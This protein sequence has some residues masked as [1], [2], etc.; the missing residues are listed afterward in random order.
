MGRVHA[1]LAALLLA[2]IYAFGAPL[3]LA[4]VGSRRAWVSAAA[5]IAVA[6]AF[7]DVLPELGE[8]Q[9]AFLQQVVGREL[10]APEYRGYLAALLGF[11]LFYGLERMTLSSRTEAL[12]LGHA[13]GESPRIYR[14]QMAGFAAYSA[15]IGYL[16]VERAAQGLLSLG[17]YS[18]AMALHF[19]VT[20]HALIHEHGRPYLSSGR[21]LLALAV[22]LGWAVGV[23]APLP[24]GVMVM[25]FGFIAGGVVINSVK[26]ELPEEGEGRFWPFCLGAGGYA[27][28]LILS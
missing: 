20:D 14:I 3:H 4:R 28:L 26:G 24:V 10:L 13:H 12:D 21:W 8:R 11:V 25:L 15:L 2:S 6:Y 16:L 22:L 1:L 9:A 18:A 19:L 5:G 23:V 27:L 17:L 7:V